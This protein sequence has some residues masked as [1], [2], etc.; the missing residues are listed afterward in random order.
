MAVHEVPE[1]DPS[2]R[3]QAIHPHLRL[4]EH[5]QD[6]R[7]PADEGFRQGRPRMRHEEAAE[8]RESPKH[9]ESCRRER[10]SCRKLKGPQAISNRGRLLGDTKQSE[11]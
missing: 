4:W 6:P 7:A 5:A 3:D 11:C 2:P 10:C 8:R 1:V 9:P